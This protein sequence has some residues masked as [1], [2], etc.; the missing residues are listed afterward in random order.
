MDAR[1]PVSC[2]I[3]PV[4]DIPTYHVSCLFSLRLPY[5]RRSSIASFVLFYPTLYINSFFFPL[6]FSPPLAVLGCFL[7]LSFVALEIYLL[8]YE[9]VSF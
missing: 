1:Q 6:L 5:S 9:Y 7:H 3:A 2:R 8:S 4:L